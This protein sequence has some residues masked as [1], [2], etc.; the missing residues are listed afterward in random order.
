MER[1]HQKD[2]IDRFE[3]FLQS[4]EIVAKLPAILRPNGP[5]G[6]YIPRNFE[7]KDIAVPLAATGTF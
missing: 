2:T 4:H 5:L 3:D 1:G 6:H 7:A